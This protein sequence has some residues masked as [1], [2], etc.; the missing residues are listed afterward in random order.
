MVTKRATRIFFDHASTTPVL[1]EVLRSMKPYWNQNF[2]NP[3]ALYEEG[4]LSHKAIQTAR[5]TIADILHAHSDEIVFTGSGTES[6]NLAIVGVV[7]GVMEQ[8][9]I[10][11]PHIIS[12]A[13]EHPA[14]LEVLK[15]LEE[16]K[17]VTVTYIIPDGDGFVHPKD[18][19]D[20]LTDAT[21]LVSVMYAN[22]EIG[23]IQ[24]IREIAKVI[25][26]FKKNKKTNTMFPYFHTDASQAANYLPLN[27]LELH[28]DLLTLDASK[29]Y[30]PKGIGLLFV[31]RGTH[32][33]PIILG[34]GQEEGRRSGTENIPS[35]VGFAKALSIVQSDKDKE[36][37][38]LFS[39]TSILTDQILKKYPSAKLN[40]SLSNRLPNIVN[41]CF[42]NIDAEFAVIKLDSLG[43]A[44]SM[45]SSCRTL[46][47]NDT[48]YV[49]ESIGRGKECAE[50]SLRLSLGR[51]STKQEVNQFLKQLKKVLG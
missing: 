11:K 29:I 45:A 19:A 49:I 35:I 17:V 51:A 10:K 5:K 3:S 2:A 44:C 25:R 14:V 22:N 16:K 32:L 6:D 30:G 7:E 26:N 1:P 24:D 20:A 47:E 21:I 12:T 34:G 33:Q 40:G 27:V 31:R 48:S 50:S 9:K 15:R 39:L 28:T 13:F 8:A 18:I 37:K 41:V 36:S 38:R 23:T 42:P 4:L 46:K 43:V